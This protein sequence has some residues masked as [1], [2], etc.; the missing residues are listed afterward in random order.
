MH[1]LL[2]STV[3]HRAQA[4]STQQPGDKGKDRGLTNLTSKWQRKKWHSEPI[5]QFPL[6][7]RTRGMKP[8]ASCTHQASQGVCVGLCLGF[9]QPHKELNIPSCRNWNIDSVSGEFSG[10]WTS[11]HWWSDTVENTAVVCPWEYGPNRLD[12]SMKSA[13][14][15]LGT[16]GQGTQILRTSCHCM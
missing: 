4:W 11:D 15:V 13:A 5:H 1:G 12:P 2:R 7:E 6:V 8:L 9:K 10:R 16:G 14:G 3:S